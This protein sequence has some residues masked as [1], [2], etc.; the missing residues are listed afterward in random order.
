MILP[1]SGTQAPAELR[2]GS[3]KPPTIPT[4][5][6][7]IEAGTLAHLSME[8]APPVS[9]DRA[10]FCCV[11]VD[12]PGIGR[13][14]EAACALSGQ[15]YA[16]GKVPESLRAFLDGETLHIEISA[17]EFED[18]RNFEL[19]ESKRERLLC[20]LMFAGKDLANAYPTDSRAGRVLGILG[21]LSATLPE[22]NPK[23]KEAAPDGETE[24]VGDGIRP[25]GIWLTETAAALRQAA[26]EEMA[27]LSGRQT[28]QC[29]VCGSSTTGLDKTERD[30]VHGSDCWVGN[31][32]IVL[33]SDDIDGEA[34]GAVNVVRPQPID[35]LCME[36]G[37]RGGVWE[38]GPAIGH[39]LTLDPT[40]R[41][42]VDA[43]GTGR[44]IW[45]HRCQKGGA[46]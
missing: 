8:A 16:A 15:P 14:H 21:D 25:R 12:T 17:A 42:A 7:R 3:E 11:G 32:L 46:Q 33:S 24:R 34:R 1:L 5:D 18:I 19:T 26:L 22:F 4:E 39:K 40:Q 43:A 35:L 38:Q 6:A 2:P 9:P 31:V 30:I 23:G 29:N 37:E 27:E 36:C 45:T 10:P 44:Y 41:V 28:W 20:E 13:V